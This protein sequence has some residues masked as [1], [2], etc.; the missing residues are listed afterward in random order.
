MLVKAMLGDVALALRSCGR[1]DID[2]RL[3][4]TSGSSSSGIVPSLA[5]C[6]VSS[7]STSLEDAGLICWVDDPSLGLAAVEWPEAPLDPDG[8]G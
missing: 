1:T 6:S 3:G 4:G 8:S 2:V 7:S 5:S